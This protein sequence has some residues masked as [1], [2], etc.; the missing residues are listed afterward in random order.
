MSSSGTTTISSCPALTSRSTTVVERRLGQLEEGR[1]DAEVG[2]QRRDLVDEGLDRG[3]G[4]GVTAP[5]SQGHQCRS[6]HLRP[7]FSCSVHAGCESR[8]HEW[9]PH[10]VLLVPAQRPLRGSSP[11]SDPAGAGPAADRRVAVVDQR[12]DEDAVLGDVALDLLV[13]PARER[14]D[15]DLA[16]LGVPA[17]HRRDHA[18]VGLGPAQPGRPGVVRRERVGSAAGPCAARSTGRGRSCRGPCRTPRPARP[19]SARA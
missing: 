1:L 16:L 5:V 13:G 8:G 11:G 19:R 4:A 15:L 6:S 10:S 17:D 9:I 18:V 2:A 12:V 7:P 14:G 3:G